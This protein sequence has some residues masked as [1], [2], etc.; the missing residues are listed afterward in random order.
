MKY[1]VF[2]IETDGLLETLTRLHCL[3]AHTYE[4]N[5]FL[6]ETIITNPWE[7]ANFLSTQDIL[8]GHNV[9]RYDFPAIKKL[10]G[11]THQGQ[12]IDTLGLSWYLYPNEAEHGLE[13][14]GERVGVAKPIIKDWENLDAEDY[15]NRCR[16]DVDINTIIFGNFVAYLKEI[17]QSEDYHRPG[18]S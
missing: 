5:Q 12:V 10:T 18:I 3:V 16:T 4:D 15:I 8:V 14:W 13:V 6:K 17:Y 1:T 11:Y 9:K 2:D 7:L